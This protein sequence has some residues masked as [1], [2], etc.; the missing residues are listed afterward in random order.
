MK[1]SKFF[2]LKRIFFLILILWASFFVS[3]CSKKNKIIGSSFNPC[4]GFSFE[5]KEGKQIVII[6]SSSGQIV[7]EL[8]PNYAPLTVANFLDLVS[9]G[10]YNNTTFH[11]VIKDPYPFIIQGGDP[12]SKKRKLKDIKLGLG[13]F[14]DPKNGK[15]RLIPLEIKLKKEEKPRYNRLVKN[16][17]EINEINLKHERGTL[18]MARS[19]PLNSASSQFYIALKR[20]PV[21]DGRYAVFG[22]IIKGMDVLDLISK[23]DRIN[24]IVHIKK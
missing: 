24:K 4:E 9:K 5:C 15:S 10:I 19:E 14:V 21:L 22:R 2:L 6:Y 16:P 3:S 23:G 12:N 8:Y 1:G 13:G 17:N 11:R 7:L 18:S 20:L